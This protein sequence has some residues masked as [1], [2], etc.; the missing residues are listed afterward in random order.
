MSQ[1]MSTYKQSRVYVC[2]PSSSKGKQRLMEEKSLLYQNFSHYTAIIIIHVTKQTPLV[3]VYLPLPHFNRFR[4]Y[5]VAAGAVE[6]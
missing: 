5:L 3:L 2:Y 4:K 6:K 1:K